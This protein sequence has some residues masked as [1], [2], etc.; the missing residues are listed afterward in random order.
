MN[1]ITYRKKK[2]KKTKNKQFFAKWSL[3]KVLPKKVRLHTTR[4]AMNEKVLSSLLISKSHHGHLLTRVS[5]N[6]YPFLFGSRL[7]QGVIDL[8]VTI[9]TLQR[10]FSFI[11]RLITDN[12][13]HYLGKGPKKILFIYQNPL[14]I[15]FDKL[16]DQ[17]FVT[18]LHTPWEQGHITK[19]TEKI[20]L[21][22]SLSVDPDIEKEAFLKKIPLISLVD[23]NTKN[24][25]IINYPIVSSTTNEQSVF[26]I[27]FMFHRFFANIYPKK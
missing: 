2:G 27:L 19:K 21:V 26:F 12:K 22:I 9:L 18:L 8:N 14:L 24:L 6:I 25:N 16:F 17:K 20:N 11:T 10:C 23:T 13:R 5:P 15:K 1:Y 4:L 7:K 3:K